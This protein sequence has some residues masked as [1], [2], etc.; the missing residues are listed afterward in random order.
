MKY[1]SCDKAGFMSLSCES[2]RVTY[3][4]SKRDGFVSYIW[5]CTTGGATL[6]LGHA[7][8]LTFVCTSLIE[9]LETNKLTSILCQCKNQVI[10]KPLEFWT[11]VC[12]TNLFSKVLGPNFIGVSA[13]KCSGIKPQCPSSPDQSLFNHGA[14]P[15]K[16]NV[17]ITTCPND[18]DYVP[19]SQADLL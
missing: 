7:T 13:T 14:T 11:V 10:N 2:T 18:T 9:Q 19:S 3:E 15:L 1:L 17:S 5:R 8:E 16:R 12:V 4:T 6:R